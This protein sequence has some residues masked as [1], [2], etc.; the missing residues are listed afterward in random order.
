[1]GPFKYNI[2]NTLNMSL[3]FPLFSTYNADGIPPDT[4]VKFSFNVDSNYPT[5]IVQLTQNLTS[6]NNNV[7]QQLSIVALNDTLVKACAIGVGVTDMTLYLCITNKENPVNESRL[8]NVRQIWS[9]IH[10]ITSTSD[11]FPL[12]APKKY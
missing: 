3:P 9:Q 11:S 10:T 12:Y 5:N 8:L 2:G 1:M 4:S 7:A 6:T